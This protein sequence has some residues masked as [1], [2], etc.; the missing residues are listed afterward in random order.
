MYVGIGEG[1][2][3]DLS[4]CFVYV[5]GM[6]WCAHTHDKYLSH[7]VPNL[8]HRISQGFEPQIGGL[9]PQLANSC[10]LPTCCVR[11]IS[12]D[13]QWQHTSHT[14]PQGGDQAAWHD[15]PPNF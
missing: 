6:A 5:G 15:G 9:V 4:L 7:H 2:Q 11:V 14:P 3:E 13:S 1:G 10:V 12:W 8:E